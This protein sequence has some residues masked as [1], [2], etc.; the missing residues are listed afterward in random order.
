[1]KI[2]RLCE[3]EPLCV[4]QLTS[5]FAFLGKQTS[6]K[7][8]R[9]TVYPST[10]LHLA[11][12]RPGLPIINTPFTFD[13]LMNLMTHCYSWFPLFAIVPKGITII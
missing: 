11:M 1:M 3:S 9:Q 5:R 8:A 12:P 10:Y 7:I 4:L 6:M 13:N 2:G